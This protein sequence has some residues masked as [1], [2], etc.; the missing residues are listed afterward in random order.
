MPWHAGADVDHPRAVAC[1]VRR[2]SGIDLF[3]SITHRVVKQHCDLAGRGSYR[4]KIA[5]HV[6]DDCADR[7]RSSTA[8]NKFV[9]GRY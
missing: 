6:N 8:I 9:G 7:E 3:H 1:F 5:N 4:A 2:G